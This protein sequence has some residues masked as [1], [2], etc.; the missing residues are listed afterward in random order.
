MGIKSPHLYH[1]PHPIPDVGEVCWGWD[2]VDWARMLHELMDQCGQ[3]ASRS[4][5]RSSHQAYPATALVV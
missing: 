2:L 3:L 4:F 5:L 1:N